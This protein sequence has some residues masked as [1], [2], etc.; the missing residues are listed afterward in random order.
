M[1]YLVD[2]NVFSEQLKP[3]PV[4]AVL[5]WLGENEAELFV[6]VITIAPHGWSMGEVWYGL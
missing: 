1:S 4:V 5:D 6:S 2:T 3:R